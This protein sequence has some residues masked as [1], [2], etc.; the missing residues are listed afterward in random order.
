MPRATDQQVNLWRERIHQQQG[1]GLSIPKWCAS[2]QIN[3]R[4]FYYW[5]N[6]QFQEQPLKE[7]DFTEVIDPLECLITVEYRG[8]KMRFQS[9]TLKEC[10]AL[11]KELTC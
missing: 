6:R 2:H 10:L 4:L 9:P 1:S 8:V 5:K 11:V 7:A 3:S